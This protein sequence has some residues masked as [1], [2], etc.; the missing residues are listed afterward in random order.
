MLNQALGTGNFT[1]QVR[2]TLDF[3]QKETESKIYSPVV[4]EEG[5]IRSHQEQGTAL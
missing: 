5:I 1:V 4:G 2:A 3:D